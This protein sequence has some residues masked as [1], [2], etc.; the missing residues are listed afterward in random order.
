LL[1]KTKM[2]LLHATYLESLRF[3]STTNI[4]RKTQAEIKLEDRRIPANSFVIFP[5]SSLARMGNSQYPAK[6]FHPERFIND[7]NQLR[8]DMQLNDKLFTPFAVGP[9]MCPGQ[10]MTEQMIK[11]YLVTLIYSVKYFLGNTFLLYD[12]AIDD[13]LQTH[14]YPILKDSIR[15]SLF[16][17]T[18]SGHSE[19]AEK[20]IE[21]IKGYCVR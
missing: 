8:D 14:I 1:D 21:H 9:R 13:N 6:Q 5:L 18:K 16:A 12:D 19:E 7:E 2:P 11:L 17:P 20:I 3:G 15:Y 4:A 10:H